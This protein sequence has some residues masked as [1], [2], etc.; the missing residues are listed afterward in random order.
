M[1]DYVRNVLQSRSKKDRSDNYKA[2]YT[3]VGGSGLVPFESRWDS[4][5]HY[6]APDT[7]WMEPGPQGPMY[8]ESKD[9][10]FN[11]AQDINDMI[12]QKG[13]SYL[14]LRGNSNDKNVGLTI[15]ENR[16]TPWG[17]TQ[18]YR[19]SSSRTNNPERYGIANSGMTKRASMCK[20]GSGMSKSMCKCG[21]G[22]KKSFAKKSWLKDLVQGVKDVPYRVN[23]SMLRIGNV[24]T[25]TGAKI[26]DRV[27]QASGRQR[28][29]A[30]NKLLNGLEIKFLQDNGLLPGRYERSRGGI[31]YKPYDFR[32]ERVAAAGK[33]AYR[34]APSEVELEAELSRFADANA[35]RTP[36]YKTENF[37]RNVENKSKGL[38]DYLN[39]LPNS[40]RSKIGAGVAS[41]FAL[42]PFAIE[43]IESDKAKRKQK[44][45]MG[46]PTYKRL[47]KSASFTKAKHTDKYFR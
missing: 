7:Y 6:N 40:T 36:G 25:N 33:S 42:S 39:S 12:R 47:S 46:T 43:R 38:S 27:S 16:K 20:C 18:N 32:P 28:A 2:L 4:D 30:E 24:Y 3:P 9:R 35:P 19:V 1:P 11:W 13:E 34:Q 23:D 14:N 15:S 17:R 45:T 8:G 41:T 22:M 37:F 29:R 31:G 5:A 21:G 44:P 10:A 26:A